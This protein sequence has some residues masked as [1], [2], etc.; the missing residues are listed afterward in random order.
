[1]ERSYRQSGS[2]LNIA[3][4]ALAAALFVGLISVGGMIAYLAAA[5]HELVGAVMLLARHALRL[6]PPLAWPVIIAIIVL[7]PVMLCR[8]WRS[9]S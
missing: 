7:W 4:N 9:A 6:V 5:Q 8:E 3:G 1:M 2:H